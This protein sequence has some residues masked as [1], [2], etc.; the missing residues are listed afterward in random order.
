[1]ASPDRTQVHPPRIE[2]LIPARGRVNKYL[3]P[4]LVLIK[5][6]SHLRFIHQNQRSPRRPYPDTSKNRPVPVSTAQPEKWIHCDDH[7]TNY[8]NID[9][10]LCELHHLWLGRLPMNATQVLIE[11]FHSKRRPRPL[12]GLNFGLI[13][14]CLISASLVII[15]LRYLLLLLI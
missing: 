1:M 10:K 6:L 13:I 3:R 11:T 8:S 9:C 12:G 4:L 15:A 7:H 2:Q 14:P 5:S